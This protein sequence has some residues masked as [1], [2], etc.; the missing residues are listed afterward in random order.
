MFLTVRLL[1]RLYNRLL[2]Y[3]RGLVFFV[4]IT[5]C[6]GKCYSIPRVHKNLIFKYPPHKGVIVGKNCYFGPNILI[7]VP[8]YAKLSI[9]DNVSFASNVIISSDNSISIGSNCLVAEFVSIRDAEHN[10]SR[11]NFIKN[12]SLISEPVIIESDV[13]IGRS[14]CVLMGSKITE[15]CII[16]ANSLIKRKTTNPFTIYVGI[17]VKEFSKRV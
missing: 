4:K 9:G 8:I 7:E 15:G 3:I 14:S 12:Q 16:G 11:N 5:I 2:E 17:P 6:G 1:I 10:Y 13:W